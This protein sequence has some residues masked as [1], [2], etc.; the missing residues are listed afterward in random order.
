MCQGGARL[1]VAGQRCKPIGGERARRNFEAWLPV[2]RPD[3][4]TDSLFDHDFHWRTGTR[5]WLDLTTRSTSALRP[6]RRR[7]RSSAADD[8][9]DDAGAVRQ[10]LN[11]GAEAPGTVEGKYYSL[12]HRSARAGARVAGPEARAELNACL[13][14]PSAI[15]GAV[16]A[17]TWKEEVNNQGL[18]MTFSAPKRRNTLD[19]TT[20]RG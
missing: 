9:E 14:P 13:P 11:P 1:E 8:A 10:I 6:G 7:R 5:L 2:R 16:T 19:R 17:K 3:V 4:I 15:E 12:L 20:M 18:L